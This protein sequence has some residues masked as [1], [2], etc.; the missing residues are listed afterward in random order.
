MPIIKHPTRTWVATDCTEV[1]ATP[2]MIA[3]YI[4]GRPLGELLGADAARRL[5]SALLTAANWVD[6]RSDRALPAER[7]GVPPGEHQARLAELDLLISWLMD[8]L[9]SASGA[10]A[11][12]VRSIVRGVTARREEVATDG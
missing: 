6:E 12:V 11:D 1:R 8:G 3:T 2:N 7:T 4:D 9:E 10:D 5:A